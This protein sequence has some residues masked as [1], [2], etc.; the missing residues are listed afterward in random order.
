M[1]TDDEIGNHAI[2]KETYERLLPYA[3]RSAIGGSS[4]V[5]NDKAVR[6]ELCLQDQLVGMFSHYCWCVWIFGYPDRFFE[7]RDWC[8]KNQ[9]QGDP[10]DFPGTNLEVKGSLWRARTRPILEHTLILPSSQRKPGTVYCL[11]LVESTT[12]F[13]AL[14]HLV[15]WCRDSELSETPETEGSFQGKYTKNARQLHRAIS[16]EWLDRRTGCNHKGPV[17]LGKTLTP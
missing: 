3:K 10:G 12:D 6:R 4:S 13:P 9:L 2:T 16:I 7:Q 8:D 1:V 14:V 5:R 15:G 11:T 17:H